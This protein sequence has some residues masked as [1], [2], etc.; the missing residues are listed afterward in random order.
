[1]SIHQSAI[2][3]ALNSTATL[4]TPTADIFTRVMDCAREYISR[5]ERHSHPAGG[6][7]SAGRF[8]LKERHECC[9]GIRS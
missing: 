1:M 3:Y 9:D 6:F 4:V 5:R 7:D 8:S 2:S